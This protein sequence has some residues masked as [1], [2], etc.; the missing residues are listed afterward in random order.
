MANLTFNSIQI[1]GGKES[2]QPI[3]D[4]LVPIMEWDSKRTTREDFLGES[5]FINLSLFESLVALPEGID[6]REFYGTSAIPTKKNNGY[7]YSIDNYAENED[8]RAIT[9]SIETAWSPCEG[10]CLQ[11]SNKYGVSVTND[12]DGD[13]IGVYTAING[14]VVKDVWW[15]DRAE[16]VYKLNPDDFNHFLECEVESLLETGDYDD[17]TFEEFLEEFKY[18][19]NEEHI[20]ELKEVFKE[21]CDSVKS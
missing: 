2:M 21:H 8:W 7:N 19:T 20:K 11:V 13:G 14:E 15:N 17:Y 1:A 12:W 6:F 9:L 4:I 18:V 3:L 5:E 16:G 10:F